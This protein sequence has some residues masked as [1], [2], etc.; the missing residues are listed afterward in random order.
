MKTKKSSQFQIN[1]HL[2]FFQ[3]LLINLQYFILQGKMVTSFQIKELKYNS[4]INPWL[5][6]CHK[7][8]ISYK[9][10]VYYPM[11]EHM[12]LILMTHFL[13]SFFIPP[14]IN[15]IFVKKVDFQQSSQQAQNVIILHFGCNCNFDHL[16]VAIKFKM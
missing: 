2:Q 4:N 5:F 12:I 15:S 7:V 13:F 11:S 3:I 16:S 8:T 6:F 14:S 9:L 10:W 1:K